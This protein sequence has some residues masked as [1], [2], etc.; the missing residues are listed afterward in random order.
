MIIA[1]GMIDYEKKLDIIAEEIS[2][3]Y[4]IP[5]EDAMKITSQVSQGDNIIQLDKE[6]AIHKDSGQIYIAEYREG[7][8]FV[9]GIT[10]TPTNEYNYEM[11]E[12]IEAIKSSLLK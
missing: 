1:I 7:R 12:I 6:T 9:R 4:M 3:L 10:W 8:R 5:K 2:I 11:L